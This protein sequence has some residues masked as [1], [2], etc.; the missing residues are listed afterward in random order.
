M[1]KE[2][3]KRVRSQHL[4]LFY[5]K[6]ALLNR[7]THAGF[8]ISSG[9]HGFGFAACEQSVRLT[10][11]EFFDAARYYPIMFAADDEDHYMPVALLG[12]KK[13]DV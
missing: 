4:P 10:A 13:N 11:V 12:L 6:P 9:A 8:I 2:K 3:E 5:K 1:E 7:Q